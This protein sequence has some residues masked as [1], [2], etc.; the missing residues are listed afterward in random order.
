MSTS[1]QIYLERLKE[2]VSEKIECVVPSSQLDLSDDDVS[3]EDPVTLSGETYLASDHLIIRLQVTATA[4]LPCSICN[5]PVSIPITLSP[6]YHTEETD[7]LPSATFDYGQELREA[8]LLETP[9]F[10]ECNQGN[11]PHR[12][13][14]ARFM[15]PSIES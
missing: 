8:I 6:F 3:F 5:D 10:A 14:I 2:G 13:T 15:T 9:L 4:V 7:R 12:K 11:C 1:L